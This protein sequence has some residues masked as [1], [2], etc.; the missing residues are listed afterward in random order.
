MGAAVLRLRPAATQR[1]F[2]LL[3]TTCSGLRST[4]M[5]CASKARIP[6]R[7]NRSTPVRQ[8]LASGDRMR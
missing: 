8:A 5:V 6:N 4:T 2:C 1:T 7:T 3:P